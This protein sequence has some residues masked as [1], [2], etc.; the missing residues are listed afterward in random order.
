VASNVISQ[1]TIVP[2][3]N[4]TIVKIRKYRGF[5]EGHRFISMAMKV[6]DAPQY[7][8]DHSIR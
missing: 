2:T 3:K 5:H 7:D 4:S 8:M 1:L 6:H